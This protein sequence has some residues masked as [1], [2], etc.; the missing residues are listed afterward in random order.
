[1]CVAAVHYEVSYLISS[2]WTKEGD[3]LMN[4]RIRVELQQESGTGSTPARAKIFLDD[5]LVVEIEGKVE[6]KQGA[7]C[8]LYPC[9]TLTQVT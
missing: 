1:M 8:G 7:D 3:V 6:A 4:D 2:S 5:Q 9:V